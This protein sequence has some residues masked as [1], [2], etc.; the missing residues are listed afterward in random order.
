MAIYICVCV[1]LGRVC[2]CYHLISETILDFSFYTI[3]Q[4]MEQDMKGQNYK[5]FDVKM[6]C[7]ED[8]AVLYCIAGNYR[9]QEKTDYIS[10]FT[11][12]VTETACI[13]I[14]SPANASFVSKFTWSKR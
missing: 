9:K 14:L 13:C 12:N 4:C 11:L 1:C 3:F 5:D 6:Y 8:M 7:Q 10:F 2:Q